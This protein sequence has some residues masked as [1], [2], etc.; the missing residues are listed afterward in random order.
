MIVEFGASLPKPEDI[1]SKFEKSYSLYHK[2]IFFFLEK[3]LYKQAGYIMVSFYE[4]LV[5][6][7]NEFK[8]LNKNDYLR[9]L[10]ARLSLLNE[11]TYCL[12]VAEDQNGY[13]VE[14][15]EY[16]HKVKRITSSSLIGTTLKKTDG[17][18][19]LFGR[20]VFDLI[21]FQLIC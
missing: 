6:A 5:L 12:D 7:D 2:V 4:N 13:L 16:K 1:L 11:A 14:N 3:E 8:M 20:K 21:N 15:V 10:K 18:T 19:W 17:L 9:I